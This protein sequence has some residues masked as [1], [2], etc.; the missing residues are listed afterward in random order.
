MLFLPLAFLALVTA[1]PVSTNALTVRDA[2]AASTI[3]PC[4]P[5]ITG[6]C[7]AFST[8]NLAGAH[9]PFMSVFQVFDSNCM[10]LDTEPGIVSLP[11]FSLKLLPP[12]QPL[13]SQQ[14]FFERDN[15]G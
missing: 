9:D 2:A 6:A 13:N 10:N 4:V 12:P 15:K 7:M 8:F 14:L 11:F 3:R 5:L 1:S